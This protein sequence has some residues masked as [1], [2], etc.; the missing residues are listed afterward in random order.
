MVG[1]FVNGAGRTLM[2]RADMDAITIRENTELP[3]ASKI[4][5]KRPDG[6]E[7]PVMYACGHDMPVTALMATAYYL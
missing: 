4:L 5:F 3:Y 1:N 2:L 6:S 7:K